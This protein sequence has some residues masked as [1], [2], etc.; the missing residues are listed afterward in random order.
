MITA[1]S[2]TN[3]YSSSRCTT[4]FGAKPPKVSTNLKKEMQE[5]ARGLNSAQEITLQKEMFP[6]LP[7]YVKEIKLE[8][9]KPEKGVLPTA[10][11]RVLVLKV[12]SEKG[13]KKSEGSTWLEKGT[14]FELQESLRTNQME[15]KISELVPKFARQ[16]F[17][18]PEY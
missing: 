1:F 2:P 14:I 13:S 4:P 16:A 11:H 3:Y 10:Q 8:L 5:F 12:N 9:L 6:G 7:S 15:T 17:E 18:E